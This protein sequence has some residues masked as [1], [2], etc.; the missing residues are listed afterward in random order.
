[1]EKKIF[2]VIACIVVFFI[3]KSCAEEHGRNDVKE[4]L[5]KTFQP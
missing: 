5:N 1:M 2:A 4:N 3:V